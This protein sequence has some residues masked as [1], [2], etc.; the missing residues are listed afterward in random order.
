MAVAI[1]GAETKPPKKGRQEDEHGVKSDGVLL[2]T[3]VDALEPG[4]I[5]LARLKPGTCFGMH[6]MQSE[7]PHFGTI[8]ALKRTH[9]LCLTNDDYLSVM[10]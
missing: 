2:E 8:K 3:P 7:R 4:Y 10:K 1:P 9:M 6:S 5:D